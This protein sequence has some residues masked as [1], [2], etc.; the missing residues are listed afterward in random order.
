M[1]YLS[2]LF[3]G[4]V[5][6]ASVGLAD[7]V[8]APKAGEPSSAADR[9]GFV[10]NVYA[11]IDIHRLT[12]TTASA[13]LSLPAGGATLDYF[14]GEVFGLYTAVEYVKRGASFAGTS[15]SANYVDAGA[16]IALR[17]RGNLFSS[18]AL[19]ILHLGAF[20]AFPLDSFA[21]TYNLPGNNGITQMY[22]GFATQATSVYPIG[23]GMWLGPASWVKIGLGS[24]VGGLT[25]SAWFVDVGLGIQLTF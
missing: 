22:M 9:A 8:G 5:A 15:S 10:A 16:G 3:L 7:E 21:G 18:T 23:G 12:G 11:G 24:P 2:T 19:N 14:L 4:L 25:Y 6:M 17:Y 13:G 20:G 1:K